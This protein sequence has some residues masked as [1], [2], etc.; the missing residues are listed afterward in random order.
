MRSALL[1]TSDTS[2]PSM[3]L[4]LDGH[5]R[6]FRVLPSGLS[7]MISTGGR[8]SVGD[9]AVELSSGGET[10]YLD[11]FAFAEGREAARDDD[12]AG[13]ATRRVSLS[14]RLE[15]A[16]SARDA[17]GVARSSDVTL[18]VQGTVSVS[19]YLSSGGGGKN[20]SK[21]SEMPSFRRARAWSE[22]EWVP[23]HEFEARYDSVVR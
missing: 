18:S 5:L 10:L 2:E 7:S 8:W 3:E 4:V 21:L 14:M 13:V 1:S 20:A 9:Y 12:D 23:V 17:A 11:L 15:Q 6:V 19:T 22:M 16:F